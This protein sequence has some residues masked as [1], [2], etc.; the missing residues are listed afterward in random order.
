M[1]MKETE[2]ADIR[3]DVN[4]MKEHYHNLLKRVIDNENTVD[5]LEKDRQYFTHEVENL[6]RKLSCKIEVLHDITGEHQKELN[7]TNFEL[8]HTW[9]SFNKT[10]H[11]QSYNVDVLENKFLCLERERSEESLKRCTNKTGKL[12]DCGY[13]ESKWENSFAYLLTRDRTVVL[14]F[15]SNET[16][17]D[18]TGPNR[19]MTGEYYVYI[20][21]T[22]MEYLDNDLLVSDILVTGDYR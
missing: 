8:N 9:Y 2:I 11:E 16:R 4:V 1:D 13:F 10:V 19:A 12:S 14:L 17:S 6:K 21:A 15:Q 18:F 5:S 22:E 3:L 20:E 7:D